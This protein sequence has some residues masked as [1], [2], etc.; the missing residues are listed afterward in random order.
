MY[1]ECT[2]GSTTYYSMPT[3]SKELTTLSEYCPLLIL[4][5]LVSLCNLLKELKP[6]LIPNESNVINFV[7]TY[8]VI[9]I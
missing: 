1:S 9:L 2:A 6:Y 5:F 3:V 4:L 8:F 7:S